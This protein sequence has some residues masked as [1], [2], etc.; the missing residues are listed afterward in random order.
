MNQVETSCNLMARAMHSLVADKLVEW[1][2]KQ[3]EIS[4][5]P[6][7]TVKAH[8]EL[9]DA[10]DMEFEEC[11]RQITFLIN[12]VNNFHACFETNPAHDVIPRLHKCRTDLIQNSRQFVWQYVLVR[13]LFHS[14]STRIGLWWSLYN[15]QAC[16]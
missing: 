7:A 5:G 4:C 6:R 2:V 12:L 16:W 3:K 11:G 8:Y 13:S 10:I 14:A 1:L 9:L 15:H